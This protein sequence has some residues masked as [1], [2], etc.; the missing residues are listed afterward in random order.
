MR[1]AGVLGPG[2]VCADCGEQEDSIMSR[3]RFN[4]RF[5]EFLSAQEGKNSRV[6]TD[7]EHAAAVDFILRSEASEVLPEEGKHRRWQRNLFVVDFGGSKKLMRK[8]SNL[9]VVTRSEIF[10][11]INDV[12]SRWVMPVETNW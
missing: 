9:E 7:E 3:E 2:R 8:E 6:M 11:R 4:V 5:D 1:S 10:D 12:H